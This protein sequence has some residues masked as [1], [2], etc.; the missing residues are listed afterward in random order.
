MPGPLIFDD[1]IANYEATVT[2][3]PTVQVSA[4]GNLTIFNDAIT[5]G[6]PADFEASGTIIA[7][8]GGNLSNCYVSENEASSFITTA[9]VDCKAWL[10]SDWRTRK[11][12]MLEATR[13]IDSMEYI[14][15]V[16]FYDQLLRFPRQIPTGFPWNKTGTSSTIYTV[17]MYRMQKNVQHACCWQT[18]HVLRNRGRDRVLEAITEGQRSGQRGISTATQAI[19]YSRDVQRMNPEALALLHEWRTGRRVVRG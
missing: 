15:S 18:L 7:S 11:A 12:A 2:S 4:S 6:V 19:A 8:W 13:D 9:I 10:D 17:T 3:T 5:S 14:G 1:G 16:Y